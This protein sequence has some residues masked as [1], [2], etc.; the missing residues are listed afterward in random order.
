MILFGSTQALEIP[1]EPGIYGFFPLLASRQRL[2][3]LGK[4]PYSDAVLLNAKKGLERRVKRIQ[5]IFTSREMTGV[6]K[7]TGKG[8]DLAES[9]SVNLTNYNIDDIVGVIESVDH[10]SLPGLVDV[11]ERASL[12]AG[13][14]YSGMT[15]SQTLLQR[16]SQHKA[17]YNNSKRRDVFAARLIQSGLRWDDLIYGCVPMSL[18]NADI[19]VAERIIHMLLKAPLSNS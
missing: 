15:R 6:V 4:P 9:Y 13:P 12:M 18:S 2:G 1:N 8:R 3:I 14:I 19:L 11:L 10:K 5:E 17:D 16:Y 7:R